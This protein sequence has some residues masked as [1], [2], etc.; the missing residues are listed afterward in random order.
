MYHLPTVGIPPCPTTL[1]CPAPP[2]PVPPHPAPPCPTPPCVCCLTPRARVCLCVCMCVRACVCA[3]IRVCV[4]VRIFVRAS[5]L[6]IFTEVY[7][8]YLPDLHTNTFLVKRTRISGD[9]INTEIRKDS[10]T[11]APLTVRG[12]G[13]L[14]RV[15]RTGAPG[16]T[17]TLWGFGS[18]VV[19][20]QRPLVRRT[21]LLAKITAE[22]E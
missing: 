2:S 12:G 10:I 9:K 16:A 17:P 22:P 11:A 18:S 13:S 20:R 6:L 5:A 7:F 4:C 15:G 19:S 8:I 1:L 14:G 3:C 21:V